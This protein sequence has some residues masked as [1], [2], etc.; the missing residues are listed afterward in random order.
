MGRG[1]DRRSI[2]NVPAGPQILALAKT[3]GANIDPQELQTR[4]CNVAKTIPFWWVPIHGDLHSGNVMVRRSDAILI[5][6]GS[7]AEGP[8]T[9]D[10]AILEISLIFGTDKDDDVGAFD[11][12][13]RFLDHAYVCAPGI[14]PPNPAAEPTRFDWLRQSIRELRHILFGCDCHYAEAELVLAAYLMRFACLEI[15]TLPNDQLRE[16]ALKRRAYA[17]IIADRLVGEVET[18]SNTETE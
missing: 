13:K 18:R 6:F 1:G 9:A 14:R 7:V 5:D 12:R 3:L 4:L 8:L 17:L 2:D 10:P 16:L 15:E 11:E